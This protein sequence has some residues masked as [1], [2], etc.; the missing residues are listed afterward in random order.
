MYFQDPFGGQ[1]G[2]F[3]YKSIRER[4]QKLSEKYCREESDSSSELD[5][6]TDSENDDRH[7]KDIAMATGKSPLSKDSSQ[8]LSNTPT[9]QMS[10]KNS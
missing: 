7:D 4:L 2:V 6:N 3:N 9:A 5:Q 1:R 8:T 10:G